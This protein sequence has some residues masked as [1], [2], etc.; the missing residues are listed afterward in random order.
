MSRKTFI[1][2]SYSTGLLLNITFDLILIFCLIFDSSWRTNTKH[3]VSADH[4]I[5]SLINVNS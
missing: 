5:I 1:A 2:I 3:N 4:I